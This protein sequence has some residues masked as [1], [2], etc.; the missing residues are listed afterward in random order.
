MKKKWL[1]ASDINLID[2]EGSLHLENP[3]IKSLMTQIYLESR[4]NDRQSQTSIELLILDMISKMKSSHVIRSSKKP[5]WVHKIPELM[6]DTETDYS[7]ASLS[8]E[9]NIHPVHLSREFHKY[10][11]TTLGKYIRQLRLN[12]AIK[13]MANKR[14]TMTEIAYQCGFYDQSH[15]INH[16]KNTY[17]MTPSKFLLLTS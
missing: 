9:L 3:L 5:N 13:L 6:M 11:G 8:K 15:F 17:K 4:I 16:F 14:Y 1:Q 7:L 2:I 10:F 12:K